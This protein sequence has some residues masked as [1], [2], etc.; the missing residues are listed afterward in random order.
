MNVQLSE[1]DTSHEFVNKVLKEYG[2][3][4]SEKEDTSYGIY[5]GYSKIGNS[6]GLVKL[7]KCTHVTALARGRSQ[8]GA[9]WFYTHFI[10]TETL[11]EAQKFINYI[12]PKI[13]KYNKSGNQGQQ[14]LYNVDPSFLGELVDY[15]YDN[16]LAGIE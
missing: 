2:I 9:D 14:D 10:P 13:K 15:H 12:K 3:E 6:L 4:Y 1:F 11:D 5:V 8:G 7:G 16:Y